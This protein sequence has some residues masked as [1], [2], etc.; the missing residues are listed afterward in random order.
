MGGLGIKRVTSLRKR[1]LSLWLP[2]YSKDGGIGSAHADES[3]LGKKA[4]DGMEST[5]TSTM[6]TATVDTVLSSDKSSIGTDVETHSSVSSAASFAEPRQHFMRNAKG[7]LCLGPYE[8]RRTLGAGMQAKVVLAK[9]VESGEYVALKVIDKHNLSL[10]YQEQINREIVALRSVSHPH[11]LRLRDVVYEA[12][13]PSSDPAQSRD[14]CVLVTELCTGGE[15]FDLM[16]YLGGFPEPVART[17]F[18]QLAGAISACHAAGVYHRDLKPQNILLDANFQL[19]VADFGLSAL[20]AAGNDLCYTYCGTRSYMA[21]EILA[22][23]AY[24]GGKADAWSVGVLLFILL[25]GSPPLRSATVDD[26][27]FKALLLRRADKFW[28]AHEQMTPAF[29]R[30]AQGIV[31]RLLV[32]EPAERAHVDELVDDPWLRGALMS[33]EALRL[34][35][36]DRRE[37]AAEA[38]KAAEAAALARRE[39]ALRQRCEGGFDAFAADTRRSASAASSSSSSGVGGGGGSAALAPPLDTWRQRE[40]VRVYGDAFGARPSGF[41]VL[42]EGCAPLLDRLRAACAAAGASSVSKADTW[43]LRAVF[44]GEAAAPAGAAAP[45]MLRRQTALE[46]Q[47]ALYTAQLDGREVAFVLA[48]RRAGDAFAARA[49]LRAVAAALPSAI[50][51]QGAAADDDDSS[52]Q[53]NA[54]AAL[55]AGLARLGAMGR[56]LLGDLDEIEA[57]PV[58]A[59]APPLPLPL[60][61]LAT[62]TAAH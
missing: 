35:V 21:P 16:L 8:V 51:P 26:W 17:Y 41:Y 23:A 3:Y 43:T 56:E 15:L 45:A 22:G 54:A 30:S 34:E 57:G 40:D 19:K 7:R 44:Q 47:L 18:V 6:S 11:V 27:W 36:M 60:P 59:A 2:C 32:A 38:Q 25:A 24:S 28:Q 9:N 1:Q 29:P 37:R 53:P 61:P 50:P 33:P 55:D 62:P 49:A 31:S 48:E 39:A 20:H 4:L 42:E 52:A 46:L 58:A 10:R 5:Q 14:S 13:L 12:R